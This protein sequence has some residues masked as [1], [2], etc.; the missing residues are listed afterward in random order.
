MDAYG[1]L[2]DRVPRMTAATGVAAFASLGLPGLVGFV[3]EFQ[4]FTGTFGV[5][6][7]L[8]GI[9]LLGLLV[10]AALFLQLLQA[11]FLGERPARWDGLSDLVPS[12]Q[13]T[14]GVLLGLTIVLGIAPRAMLDTI[15]ATADL[16]LRAGT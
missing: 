9:G 15:H 4:I 10:T 13:A 11:V 3:A 14:L 8:A 1:G 12:E 2:A 6:P 16:L 7:W 5:F